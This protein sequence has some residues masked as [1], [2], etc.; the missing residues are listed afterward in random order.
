MLIWVCSVKIRAIIRS[1]DVVSRLSKVRCDRMRDF[2]SA[3][4]PGPRLQ[5][6]DS[7]WSGR[8]ESCRDCEVKITVAVL[9]ECEAV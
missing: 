4:I 7:Y 2:Q 1:V 3:D 5:G 8:A 9:Q 6:S